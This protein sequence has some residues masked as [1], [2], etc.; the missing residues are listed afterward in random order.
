[1]GSSRGTDLHTGRVITMLALNRQELTGVIRERP[2]FSLLEM[3][4]RFFIC[5]IVLVLTGHPTGMTA[6]AFCFIDDHSVSRH[7]SP[8]FRLSIVD[9]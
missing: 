3:V 1:M 2:V 4:I 8:N 9:C 7:N 5:K 6:Y